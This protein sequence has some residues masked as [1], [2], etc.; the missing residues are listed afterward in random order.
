MVFLS[1]GDGPVEARQAAEMLKGQ[2]PTPEAIEAAAETAA[3][4]DVDPSSDI[5]ATADYRRHLVR[6]LTRRSL[7]Q[8]F[9][10]AGFAYD[11]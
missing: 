3:S 2:T 6:V 11:E 5:H 4:A 10:R 8:A 1:V 9:E 7:E